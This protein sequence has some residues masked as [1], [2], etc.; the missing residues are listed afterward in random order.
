MK[1]G[2]DVLNCLNSL[3]CIR[4]QL[5]NKYLKQ[6]MEL[7]EQKLKGNLFQR[8]IAVIEKV[9]PASVALYCI[10][11]L[12]NLNQHCE[13]SSNVVGYLNL[14]VCLSTPE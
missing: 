8:P 4:K 6:L 13:C 1:S 7:A 3:W 10:S 2:K 5:Y 9:L 12:L 14:I 11:E